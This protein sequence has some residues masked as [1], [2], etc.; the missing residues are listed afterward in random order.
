[1]AKKNILEKMTDAYQAAQN[2]ADPGERFYA[3]KQLSDKID[4]TIERKTDVE[5]VLNNKS[6]NGSMLGLFS[7]GMGAFAASPLLGVGT[8]GVCASLV[9]GGIGCAIVGHKMAMRNFEKWTVSNLKNVVPLIPALKDLSAQVKK[10]KDAIF[11][12]QNL[13]ALRESKKVAQLLCAYPDLM[14]RFNDI[15]EKE[16]NQQ[17]NTNN[18]KSKKGFEL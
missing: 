10:D 8:L 12:D 17:K 2:L 1:M 18:P 4:S 9:V 13:P 15:A 5:R 11:D 16:F 6:Q 14:S 7:A 3:L